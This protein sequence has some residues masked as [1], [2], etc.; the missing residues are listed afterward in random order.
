MQNRGFIINILAIGVVL[1]ILFLSQRSY[2][3]TKSVA[4]SAGPETFLTRTQDWF[5]A[6]VYPKVSGGVGLAQDKITEQKDMAA[7][8]IWENI[9]H[10]FAQ[11]FSKYS[12]TKVE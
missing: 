1:G 5:F 7:K 6:Q 11:K 2:Y 3:A 8:N 10:Y 12:G 4:D 9:K